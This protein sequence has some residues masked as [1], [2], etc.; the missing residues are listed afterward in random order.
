M[1]LQGGQQYRAEVNNTVTQP[2]VGIDASRS[3]GVYGASM[4]VQPNAFL[5]LACVKI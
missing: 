4:T 3:S 5:M 2:R 1:Y